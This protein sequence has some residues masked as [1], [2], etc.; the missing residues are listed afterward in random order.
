MDTRF[1]KADKERIDKKLRKILFQQYYNFKKAHNVNSMFNTSYCKKKLNFESDVV[2][3]V[4]V[5]YLNEDDTPKSAYFSCLLPDEID[6]FCMEHTDYHE[7][8][9]KIGSRDT[10]FVFC[11]LK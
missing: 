1:K 6:L 11:K 5:M 3:P 8:L 2:V 10:I 7:S 4:C 9:E